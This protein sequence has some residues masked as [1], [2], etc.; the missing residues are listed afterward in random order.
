M[1][2]SALWHLISLNFR[3]KSLLGIP[4]IECNESNQ[5]GGYDGD[6]VRNHDGLDVLACV[7]M[8]KSKKF[9]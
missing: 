8:E 6:Q 9:W 1:D 2:E 5:L 7:G 3:K 4:G